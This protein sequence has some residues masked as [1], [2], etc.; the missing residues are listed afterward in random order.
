MSRFKELIARNMFYPGLLGLVVNPFF[1][2]R[3][4]LLNGVKKQS[5]MLGGDILD[6]GCGTKPYQ[7]LFSFTSYVG[8]D[9]HKSG[10]DHTDEPVDIFYDGKKFP[11]EDEAFDSVICNQVLEH[12][13]EP[14]ELLSEIRRVLKPQG[15]FL[16]TVP[17]TWDEHEQPYDYARYSSFGLRYLIEKNGFDIVVQEKLTSDLSAITQLINA[18]IY[19][20]S[21]SNSFIRQVTTVFVMCPINI[22]GFM[23]KILPSNP[24]LYLDNL[25]IARKR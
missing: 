15:H 19:K 21:R 23:L 7:E 6:V 24:D 22:L 17:F 12:V 16:L 3:R 25:V 20:I 9:T 10:H 14:D 13:F 5:H 4:G 2:A 1:H 18:Y 8:I 11:L